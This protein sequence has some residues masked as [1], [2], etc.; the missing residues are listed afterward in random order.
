MPSAN[1]SDIKLETKHVELDPVSDEQPEKVIS[2]LEKL[3]R[4]TMELPKLTVNEKGEYVSA[5]PA[6]A[7]PSETGD[8]AE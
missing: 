6:E 1:T 8:D 5:D 4:V 7:E 2:T 3:E